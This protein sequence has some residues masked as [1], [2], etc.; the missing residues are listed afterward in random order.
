MFCAAGSPAHALCTHAY[1]HQRVC[2]SLV[3]VWYFW[4]PPG[5]SAANVM[6][7]GWGWG[8]G[9]GDGGVTWPD[10]V[11]VP[12]LSFPLKCQASSVLRCSTRYLLP[13]LSTLLID[14][15][16]TV[17]TPRSNKTTLLV[18]F[19]TVK[20]SFPAEFS[21]SYQQLL[22]ASQTEAKLC[23]ERPNLEQLTG[24]TWLYFFFIFNHLFCVMNEPFYF[25]MT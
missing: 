5:A 7:W 3:C 22:R 10:S 14:A 4:S 23:I 19:R 15:I 18:P 6:G 12:S 2:F 17:I 25:D 13:P 9:W 16:F 20:N 1:T 8:W 24:T 11:R 21:P